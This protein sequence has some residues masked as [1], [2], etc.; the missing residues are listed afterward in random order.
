MKTDLSIKVIAGSLA[1]GVGLLFAACGD[2]TS[3]GSGSASGSGSGGAGGSGSGGAGGSDT[4]LS[5]GVGG[6]QVTSGT[7]G[8]GGEPAC[9]GET[10]TAELVPLD[11][12]IMLDKSG[13]MLDKTGPMANGPSKWEAVTQGLNAFFNDPQSAG[14]GV[15]LQYFPLKVPGVPNTCTNNNDCPAGSGPCLLKGCFGSPTIAVCNSNADCPGS[16]CVNLGQCSNN[17]NYYCYQQGSACGTD[18]NGNNLGNCVAIYS[19]YCANQYSCDAAQYGTADVE[20]D[21]LNGSAAA[22]QASIAMI[23]PSGGTPTAPALQ[24]AI[25]HASA[26]ATANPTHKVV[27]VLATDGLPTSCN[28]VDIPSIAQIAQTGAN[29]SPSVLTFVIGVFAGNDMN[30]QQ[31]LDAIAMAGGTTSAFLIDA[32]QNVTQAF[33]DALNA[34]RGTKLDCEYL[35]PAPPPGEKLD[36]N[37]VNVEHTAPGAAMPET[38]FYVTDASGCDP[39]TGGWYYDADPAK[40]GTP[41]KIQMCPATCDSFSAKGGQVDIRLGCQTEIGPPK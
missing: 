29:A 27:T 2:G 33:I 32:N 12:Y 15:G 6:I 10:K 5:A 8:A 28:P 26:W 17:A 38:I 14:L 4:T 20:F 31:N 9:A 18:A 35:V 30:A 7:G 40:G 11:I 34:I 37:K 25:D 24:G 41:T 36:Y 13:S 23:T 21:V 16:S 3:E 39:V 22:L 19:T 1:I